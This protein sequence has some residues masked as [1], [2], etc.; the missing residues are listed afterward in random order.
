MN[1]SS[2]VTLPFSIVLERKRFT[3]LEH[4]I[5]TVKNSYD[6]ADKKGMEHYTCIYNAALFT[7]LLEQDF[8]I[9]KNDALMSVSNLRKNFVARQM[10]VF[11]YEASQDLPSV[12][13]KDFRASLIKVGLKEDGF[14]ELNAVTKTLNN[15]K[16]KHS[17]FLQEIRNYAGAHRDHDALRQIEII[18][19]IDLMQLMTIAGDYYVPIR[20]LFPFFTKVITNMKNW[21]VILDNLKNYDGR[22][23]ASC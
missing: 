6:S 9:L 11:L 4:A 15:F 2:I 8:A 13:G 3:A 12:L 1:L 17:D 5:A 14:A 22:E 23:D 10:A 19:K 18:E 21:K 7:L 20:D 16:T